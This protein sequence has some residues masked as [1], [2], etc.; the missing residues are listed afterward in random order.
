MKIT[1]LTTTREEKGTDSIVVIKRVFNNSR[2]FGE[3]LKEQS[4]RQLDEYTNSR[5]FRIN[6]IPMDLYYRLDD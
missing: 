5:D 3:T 1:K 4:E 6:C 2:K